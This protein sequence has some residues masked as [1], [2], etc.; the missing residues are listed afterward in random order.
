MKRICVLLLAGALVACKENNPK[1]A[2][3]EAAEVYS[4]LGLEY[5]AP[6]E[7]NAKLDSNLAVAQKNFEADPSEENYIWLGR[8]LAYKVKYNQAIE[9]F[10]NGIEQYPNSYKLYRHRGHRYLSQRKF[11][12]AIEDFEKAAELM[13]AAPIEIE[14]DGVP[15]K[16]N[17]PLSSTQ[18]NVWYHLGLAH[19]LKGEF[20]KAEQA[21]L[22]CMDVSDNDDLITATV[23]WLYMTYRRQ[24]KTDEAAKLLEKITPDMTI[25]ENDSYYKRLK[26]YQG[27]LPVDSVLNVNS[28]NSDVDLALATQGY[29]VGNWYLYNGDTAQ[30]ISVFERVVGGK[31]FSAFG[32]IAAEAD[33]ARLR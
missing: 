30:A 11:D 31:H 15:N 28:T 14:P 22:K 8:R 33:L 6:T 25:V 1:Q 3:A 12:A 19:Y 13:P 17:Q 27:A 7:P 20:E 29:G 18:F 26:L 5:Y 10:T 16:I 32:F 21:Y 24:G 23:D 9:V 4:L 2:A